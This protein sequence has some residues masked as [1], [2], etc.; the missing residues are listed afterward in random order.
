MNIKHCIRLCS[1][2]NVYVDQLIKYVRHDLRAEII[3]DLRLLE[4]GDWPGG[5]HAKD[6][7]PRC[8]TDEEV[9]EPW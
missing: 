7:D 3:H 6:N 8:V 9:D 2:N 5:V 4:D 1:K